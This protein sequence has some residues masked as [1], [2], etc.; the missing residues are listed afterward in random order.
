MR[1]L[2][3]R[4]L[5]PEPKD[6]LQQLIWRH[7]QN[8][9]PASGISVWIGRTPMVHGARIQ[10]RIFPLLRLPLVLCEQ[11]ALSRSNKIQHA[12]FLAFRLDCLFLLTQIWSIILQIN[13]LTFLQ[14]VNNEHS[15]KVHNTEAITLPTDDTLLNFFGGGEP[16]CFHWLLWVFFLFMVKMNNPCL[17]LGHVSLKK[18]GWIRFKAG[19]KRSWNFKH[20]QVLVWCQHSGRQFALPLQ[21]FCQSSMNRPD[22]DAQGLCYVLDC[23][24]PIIHYHTMNPFHLDIGTSSAIIMD[25]L[26]LYTI[27]IPFCEDT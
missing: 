21:D 15:H 26:G 3:R 20:A 1:S 13:S 23:H 2:L 18:T 6:S 5:P 12:A 27:L 7:S 8:E 22:T 24:A 10:S 9:G 17:I 19:E 16:A 14:V 25:F 11:E 4:C